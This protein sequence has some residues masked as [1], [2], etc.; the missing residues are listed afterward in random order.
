MIKRFPLTPDAVSMLRDKHTLYVGDFRVTAESMEYDIP[1]MWKYENL[2]P[3]ILRG[4]RVTINPDAKN[5]RYL[6][7]NEFVAV[8][9]KR[10]PKQSLFSRLR[11]SDLGRCTNIWTAIAHPD[12]DAVARRWHLT[13]NETYA[14]FLVQNDKCRQKRLLGTLTPPWEKIR[15]E[16]HLRTL[17]RRH[18][19]GFVKR[20]HGSGGFAIYPLKKTT[21][22]AFSHLFLATPHEWFF[23]E[24]VHGTFCSIQLVTENGQTTIFGFTEQMLDHDHYIGSRILP[25]H[26]LRKNGWNALERAIV[27]LRPLWKTYSGFW[28]IDFVLNPQGRIFVLEANIRLTAA[29]IPTLLSNLVQ[30]GPTIFR[31]DARAYRA[32]NTIPL[33]FDIV[34]KTADILQFKAKKKPLGR[35]AHRIDG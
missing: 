30:S 31:E 12:A 20:A 6:H 9:K 7:R 19:T 3:W 33:T 27:A 2:L 13:L 4:Q 32:P 21:D 17:R 11:K 29:T 28:G 1:A 25:L 34:K 14:D 24:E 18:A 35:A 26:S 5:I 23:E 8:P 22:P 10:D 16:T 15:N